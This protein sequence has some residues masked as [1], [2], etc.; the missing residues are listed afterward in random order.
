MAAGAIWSISLIPSLLFASH[1]LSTR[2]PNSS[3]TRWWPLPCVA[4][5]WVLVPLLAT[6]VDD[7]LEPARFA[8]WGISDRAI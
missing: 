2:T 7:S 1:A 3:R 8:P 6:G 5:A 4:F